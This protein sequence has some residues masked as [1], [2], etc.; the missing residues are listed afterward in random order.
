MNAGH[1]ITVKVLREILLEL[2]DEDILTPNLADNLTIYRN[3]EYLGFVD[4]AK[5]SQKIDFFDALP[6]CY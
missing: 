5:G 4:L 3:G 6:K 1:E 2:G